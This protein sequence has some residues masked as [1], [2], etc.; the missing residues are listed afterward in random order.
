MFS[1]L[2][3]YFEDFEQEYK[4]RINFI[5][6]SSIF[7]LFWLIHEIK[8]K[9]EL[10]LPDIINIPNFIGN[11]DSTILALGGGLIVGFLLTRATKL[12]SSKIFRLSILAGTLIGLVQN[13]LIETKF[14]MNLLNQP[15]VSDPLDVLWGTIFCLVAC[16]VS[17]KVEKI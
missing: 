1:K 5:G 13:I 9:T 17:F 10:K 8:L 2:L 4:F 3:N 11:V 16:F 12:N 14:G 6:L 15:N 7:F